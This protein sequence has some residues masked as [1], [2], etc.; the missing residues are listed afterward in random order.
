MEG[1]REGGREGEREGEREE[2]CGWGEG[3]RVRERGM[4]LEEV[5]GSNLSTCN[6][7]VQHLSCLDIWRLTILI[8]TVNMAFQFSPTHLWLGYRPSLSFALHLASW[9]N[10]IRGRHQ[11][12][13]A[14]QQG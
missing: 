6:S 11:T 7:L 14:L 8:H 13:I 3:A 12:T 9:G 4:L 10:A 5:G 1:V 2:G